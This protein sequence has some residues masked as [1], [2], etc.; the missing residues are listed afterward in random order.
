MIIAMPP[1]RVFWPQTNNLELNHGTMGMPRDGQVRVFNQAY[2]LPHSEPGVAELHIEHWSA[3]DASFAS[4]GNMVFGDHYGP[5]NTGRN[6]YIEWLDKN[7]SQAMQYDHRRIRRFE[8]PDATDSDGKTAL[9]FPG[10]VGDEIVEVKRDGQLFAMALCVKT[11]TGTRIYWKQVDQMTADEVY[12]WGAPAPASG[13]TAQTFIDNKST[14]PG[15]VPT[16]AFAY[17][18]DVTHFPQGPGTGGVN[19]PQD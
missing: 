6:S 16:V 12:E 1:L 14:D 9:P 10:E 19:V 15:H 11:S 13:I 18:E 7:P 5:Y 3:N 8:K 17:Y 2:T 4:V